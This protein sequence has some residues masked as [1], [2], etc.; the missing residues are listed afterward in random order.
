M[1]VGSAATLSLAPT[2]PDPATTGDAVGLIPRASFGP[3]DDREFEIRAVR[4]G[5]AVVRGT[6]TRFTL[7]FV[8]E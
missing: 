4:R 8:V 5:T 6:G 7:T 2:E 1:P 3:T